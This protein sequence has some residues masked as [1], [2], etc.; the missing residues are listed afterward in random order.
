MVALC[1]GDVDY[2]YMDA[3]EIL[4]ELHKQAINDSDA[5]KILFNVMRAVTTLPP[6][7]K[8]QEQ[9]RIDY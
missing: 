6:E 3:E 4:Y 1:A 9:N 8:A 7:R 2:S 5:K